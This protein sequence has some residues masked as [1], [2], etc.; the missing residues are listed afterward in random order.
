MRKIIALSLL[1]VIGIPFFTFAATTGSS[2]AVPLTNP[3]ESSNLKQLIEKITDTVTKVIGTL[4]VIM[5]LIAGILFL[6]S[7]GDPNR[8]TTAKTC[9]FYA[10][11][12]IAVA[13]GAKAVTEVIEKIFK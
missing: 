2:T 12:G 9:L 10:I 7:A 3:L 13:L 4:A 11:I 1:T 5:L 6:T 8:M